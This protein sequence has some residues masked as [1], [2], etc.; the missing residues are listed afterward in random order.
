MR[1]YEFRNL[2]FEGGGVKG[3][4]YV[5]AL[6]R[7]DDRGILDNLERVGGTSAGAITAALL[8]LGYSL[9]ELRDILWDLDF[10]QFLDDSWGVVRD[11]ERVFSDYGWYRGEAFREWIADRVEEKLG[12]PEATFQDLAEADDTLPLYVCGTNLCT[13]F[14]DV[15]SP[16]HPREAGPVAIADAVRISMSIPLFFTAVERPANNEIYV[17]GGVVRNYPVKLFDRLGYIAEEDR[18]RHDRKTGYYDRENADRGAPY[19]RNPLVYN[20]GTLGFRLDSSD[21]IRR[22]REGEQPPAS[23]IDG[24]PDYGRALAETLLNVQSNQHL[25]SDDWQRTI[26]IDT[27]DVSAVDFDLSC[28]KKEQLVDAGKDGVEVYF[29]FFDDLDN[30]P[31][32]NHPEYTAHDYWTETG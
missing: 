10:E 21:E 26:Y 23:E 16:D 12:D 5:G 4:A 30:D 32:V 13:G 27:G 22:F 17:D 11:T 28:A 8:A 18:G 19:D 14:C 2:V 1:D 9:E 15:F 3:I 24:F 20:K 6:E 31:A 25:H 7:L 29:D